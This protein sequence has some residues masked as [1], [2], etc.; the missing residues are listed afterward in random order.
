MNYHFSESRGSLWK[1]C[2]QIA[3]QQIVS[4]IRNSL[5]QHLYKVTVPILWTVTRPDLKDKFPKVAQTNSTFA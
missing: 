3:V 5:T 2:L 4:E 1:A